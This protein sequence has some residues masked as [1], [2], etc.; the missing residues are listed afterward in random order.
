MAAAIMRDYRGQ[1]EVTIGGKAVSGGACEIHLDDAFLLVKGHRVHRIAYEEIESVRQSGWT[2]ELGLHP[3]GRIVLSGLD[4]AVVRPL[5][6][7]LSRLRGTRWAELLRFVEGDVL[8]EI[9]CKFALDG[10]REGEALVRLYP[11]ALVVLP[12]G[13]EPFQLGLHETDPIQLAGYRL[14]LGHLRTATTLFGGEPGSLTR[15]HGSIVRARQGIEDETAGLLTELFPALE[16]AQLDRLTA[17][18]LRGKAASKRDIDAAVPW[19]WEKIEDVVRKGAKMA[20]SYAYLRKRAGDRLWFGLR[21]LTELEKLDEVESSGTEEADD[22]GEPE[23]E[24]KP[25]FLFWFMAGI[26]AAGSHFLAVEIVAGTTGY[27]TY[28]YRALPSSGGEES[29]GATAQLV[30]RT[31]IALNFHREPLYASE[32][33]IETGEFAEYKLAL[34]KLDYLRTARS[35]F[36]GRAI[37][38]AAW[39]SSVEKLLSEK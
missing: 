12:F 3:E 18:L 35:L 14:V 39:E 8:D 29:F 6:L 38:T 21:R 7:H 32:K 2:V 15:F 27:A 13:G 34:R 11:A 4:G 31:L 1:H 37:H 33:E 24:T 19:L 10:G 20:E 9:E 5:F 30:S 28:V 16:F 17:L 22:D 26:P 23:P 25:D 36:V